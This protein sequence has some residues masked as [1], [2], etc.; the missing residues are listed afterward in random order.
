[1]FFYAEEN[2]YIRRV[3]GVDMG[4]PVHS[5]HMGENSALTWRM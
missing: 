3:L 5:S 2:S 4:G 1:M